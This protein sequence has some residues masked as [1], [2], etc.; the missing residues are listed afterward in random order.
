MTVDRKQ[1]ETDIVQ[2]VQARGARYT[3]V[4]LRTD[5]LE[6]GLLDSLLLMDLIFHIEEVYGIRFDSNHVNPSNFRTIMD[7]V[8]FVLDQAPVSQ[9]H[10]E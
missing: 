4:T 2:L 9:R 10:P 5:L 6:S 3:E 8:S 1:L 7:I